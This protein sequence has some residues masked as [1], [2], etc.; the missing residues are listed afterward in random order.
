M[1]IPRTLDNTGEDVFK[2]TL[3]KDQVVKINIKDAKKKELYLAIFSGVDLKIH[4]KLLDEEKRGIKYDISKKAYDKY[5]SNIEIINALDNLKGKRSVRVSKLE[6]GLK[7]GTYLFGVMSESNVKKLG[8][9]YSLS[10]TK[11]AKKYVEFESNN[12]IKQANTIIKN[13]LYTATLTNSLDTND[14][15]KVT[16]SKKG[17]LTIKS[18]VRSPNQKTGF[19]LYNSS[20][21]KIKYRIKTSDKTTTLESTVSKGTYY[22]KVQNKSK[23]DVK[24]VKYN[25]K[26]SVK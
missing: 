7:K 18:T 23:T 25:L 12:A 21:K 2:V 16:V 15:Y 24:Q 20:K 1:S 11:S 26:A 13:K 8:N 17:K 9:K 3:K 22:I 4:Q 6:M 10:I 19:T 14:Y 5:V